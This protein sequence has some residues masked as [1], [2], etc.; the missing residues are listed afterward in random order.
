MRIVYLM[1]SPTF[2]MHQYT[3]DLANRA[4]QHHEVHLITT[5][6]CRRDR[7]APT[8][9]IHTPLITTA[10]AFSR[11]ALRF[12]SLS[13]IQRIIRELEAELV[14]FTG[15]HLWNLPLVRWLN[16]QG[17]PVIHTIHDLEP[18]EK[19]LAAVPHREWNRMIVRSADSILVHGRRYRDSLTASG[20]SRS[21]VRFTPLLHLFLSYQATAAFEKEDVDPIYEPFALFFGRL[22]PYKGLDVLLDAWG[23][24]PFQ[25]RGGQAGNRIGLVI[26]GE[27]HLPKT[28][29]QTLP[30]GVEV[31]NKLVGDD[32]AIDLFR[33]CSLVILPYTG[34]T[35]SAL[36]GAAYRFSKPV[37]VTRSGALTE[38]VEEGKTG[39]VVEP[40]DSQGLAGAVA[41]AFSDP[42]RLRAMGE[43]GRTWYETR[44]SEETD[45]LLSLYRQYEALA[46]NEP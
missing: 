3:A 37:L 14:H 8:L 30:P 38:S 40:N 46:K 16:W 10:T 4:A 17:I 5:A 29:P 34:A 41:A 21:E 32:E 43:A 11:E 44:R 36:I 28:A 1:L 42:D 2:G 9:R 24:L 23:R 19:T 18:H 6:N 39:F 22:K 45:S 27:G 31:L 26:A 13:K 35:Q 25:V 15:P 7:Y 20:W 33:R 12:W